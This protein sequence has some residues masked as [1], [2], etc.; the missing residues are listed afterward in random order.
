MPV[1]VQS[2]RSKKSQK[3]HN[4]N[5]AASTE[6]KQR[7]K[8]ATDLQASVQGGLSDMVRQSKDGILEDEQVE[9]YF[10]GLQEESESATP[11][12]VT[13]LNPKIVKR[14]ALRNGKLCQINSHSQS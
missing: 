9:N 10:T 6:G 7:R 13:T 11:K 1:L 14:Y 4:L 5:R 8:E 2:K 3:E 12:R